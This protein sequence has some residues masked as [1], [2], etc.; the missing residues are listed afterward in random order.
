MF[1]HPVQ[2]WKVVIR[3]LYHILIFAGVLLVF[4]LSGVAAA[5]TLLHAVGV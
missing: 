2:R 4:V 5:D 1:L 3:G